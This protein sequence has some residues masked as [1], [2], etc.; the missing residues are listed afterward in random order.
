MQT[1]VTHRPRLAYSIPEAAE[2][3]AIGRTYVYDLIRRGDLPTVKS[4]RR[5]LIRH[6][7]LVAYL[8]TLEGVER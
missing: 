5:R 4:G 3:L 6:E 2:L 1:P 8:D 7:A